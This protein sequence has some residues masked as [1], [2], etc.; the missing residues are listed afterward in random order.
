MTV[1]AVRPAAAWPAGFALPAAYRHLRADCERFFEAYPDYGRNVFLMMPFDDRVPLLA[2]VDEEVRRTLCRRGLVGLRADDRAFSGDDQLW[3]NVCVYMLCCRYG[4][5]VLEDRVRDEFNPNVALE[6]GFMRGLG[7]RVLLLADHA[8]RNLRADVFGTL[9][10]EFDLTDVAGTLPPALGRWIDGL[11]V[12]LAAGASELNRLA[13]KAYRRLLLVRCSQ[14]IRDPQRRARERDDE[15]WYFGE[16]I[17]AYRERLREAPDAA[18]QA[19]VDAADALVH[20]DHDRVGADELAA[21]A[22][23]FEALAR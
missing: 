16:E 23:R 14:W 9:R 10:Q 12:D 4:V 7:R 8:F 15:Y 2:Q 3:N 11:G 18:H 13:L 17:R 6:Y 5:A 21:L 22:A 1:A 19:A 20:R